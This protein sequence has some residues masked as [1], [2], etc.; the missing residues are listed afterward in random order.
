MP[1]MFWQTSYKEP[2]ACLPENYSRTKVNQTAFSRWYAHPVAQQKNF[3]FVSDMLMNL[4]DY[5]ISV[6]LNLVELMLLDG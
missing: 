2:V 3:L 1:L 6:T 4:T 5:A